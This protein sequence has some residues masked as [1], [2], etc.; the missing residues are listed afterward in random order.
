MIPPMIYSQTGRALT[1]QFEGCRL[2]AYQDQAGVWTIGYGHTSGV[3][4]GMTCTQAQA[5]SWLAEDIQ[6]AADVVNREVE[7][8]LSQGEFDALVDFVFNAGSGNFQSST[9]LRL[10]NS[11]DLTDAAAQFDLWDHAGGQVV[12]GLLRRRQAET[13]EFQS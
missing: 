8:A 10:I 1:E 11:G 4:E 7:V 12:A 6:W 5:D 3:S 13:A 9:L 2:M